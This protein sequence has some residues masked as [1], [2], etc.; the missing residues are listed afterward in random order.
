MKIIDGISFECIKCGK[1]CK[2]KGYV[3]LNKSDIK[4]MSDSITDGDEHEFLDKYT[5]TINKVKDV[6]LINKPESKECIFLEDNE[7][8][9]YKNKPEQCNEFPVSYT[10]ECPGFRTG[11]DK[12][13][14]KMAERV[15]NMNARLSSTDDFE[16][17][18]TNNLYEDLKV[19]IKAASVATKAIEGGVSAFFDQN[20][21]KIASLDDLF[22]FSR[23]D[24]KHIVHKSTKD[25]WAIES[26]DDGSVHITRLFESGKPIKG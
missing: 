5:R 20:R 12:A 6:V 16:K 21:I 13:M 15:A 4:R 19:T 18:V 25:L 10:R 7:C 17:A 23:V 24:D 14:D 2:W 9:I 22:A 3:F 11:E 8:S 26:D 1:C